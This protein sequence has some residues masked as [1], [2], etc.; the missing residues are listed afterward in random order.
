MITVFT[1]KYHDMMFLQ[2]LKALY[3]EFDDIRV[4]KRDTLRIISVSRFCSP[5]K[6]A[7]AESYKF[8]FDMSDDFTKLH[9][10]VMPQIFV[11][12]SRVPYR[13]FVGVTSPKFAPYVKHLPVI[14][15]FCCGT[16]ANPQNWRISKTAMDIVEEC[17]IVG[18]I[19]HEIVLRYLCEKIVDA[20]GGAGGGGQDIVN[21]IWDFLVPC[22]G[23]GIY[24]DNGRCGPKREHN[25][26]SIGT[27][28]NGYTFFS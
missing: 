15:C 5:D 14:G 2:N 9:K 10:S 1:K 28:R 19:K 17:R 24:V 7:A 6:G 16:Y 11:G 25:G 27:I 13:V 3:A 21:L 20:R 23:Y 12:E 8:I 26:R 18:R 22:D 4:E